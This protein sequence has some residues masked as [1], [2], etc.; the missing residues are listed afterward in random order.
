MKENPSA[1]ILRITFAV[2]G[3]FLIFIFTDAALLECTLLNDRFIHD[4]LNS[5]DV[6]EYLMEVTD[7]S[8]LTLHDIMRESGIE[9]EHNE[10]ISEAFLDIALEDITDLVL[11]GDTS[12][13]EDKW[14]DFF[15][16]YGDEIFENMQG[17]S[18]D[19][20]ELEREMLSEYEDALEKYLD[21]YEDSEAYDF[22]NG[23]KKWHNTAKMTAVITGTIIIAMTVA[24]LAIHR[25][26]FLPVRAMGISATVAEGL[27]LAG[28][29][30]IA[31]IFGLLK[32]EARHEEEIILILL[33]SIGK[34]LT[35]IIGVVAASFAA[36]I[37]LIV[38]GVVGSKNCQNTDDQ[39]YE[40]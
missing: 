18:A 16:E 38:I 13:D 27:N 40:G 31:L 17:S 5:K 15:D 12:T 29:G 8:G 28:W 4:F 20:R 6:K 35:L 14:D 7:D 32:E 22:F 2:L 37:A 36:G 34:H 11:N 10:E 21:E 3:A 33:D 30:L 9:D 19:K 23:F 1:N 39:D 25:N 26:R 24:L